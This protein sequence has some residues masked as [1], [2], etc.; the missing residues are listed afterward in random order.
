MTDGSAAGLKKLYKNIKIR[1]NDKPNQSFF[2]GFSKKDYL[3]TR[4]AK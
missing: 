4:I 3:Y 2:I 1:M